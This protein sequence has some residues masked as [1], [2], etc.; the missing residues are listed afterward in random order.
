M[1]FQLTTLES[2]LNRNE[3]RKNRVVIVWK[4]QIEVTTVVSNIPTN[5]KASFRNVQTNFAECIFFL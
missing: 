3:E 4:I 2:F 1:Q 5:H